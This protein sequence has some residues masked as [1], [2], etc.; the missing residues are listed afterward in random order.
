MQSEETGKENRKE[1]EWILN[2][3]IL[4]HLHGFSHKNQLNQC[5]W[6]YNTNKDKKDKDETR[7]FLS[8][9]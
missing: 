2:E 6:L 3:D 5:Y 4:F 1:I 8:F 9:F 7:V